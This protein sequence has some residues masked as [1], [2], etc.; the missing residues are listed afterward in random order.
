[1][2]DFKQCCGRYFITQSMIIRLD[3]SSSWVRASCFTSS[4]LAERSK[5]AFQAWTAREHSL[6]SKF[7]LALVSSLMT[8]SLIFFNIFR[9]LESREEDHTPAS[10]KQ[11]SSMMNNHYQP[12]LGPIVEFIETNW[13]SPPLLYFTAFV[14]SCTVSASPILKFHYWPVLS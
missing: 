14:C 10:C 11:I 7:I 6:F 8:M 1:M 3:S 9:N 2:W 5:R 13:L 4:W 12:S